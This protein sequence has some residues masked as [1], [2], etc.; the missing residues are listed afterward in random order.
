MK[1]AEISVGRL[2]EADVQFNI[3]LFQRSYVWD[4]SNQW[5]PLWADILQLTSGLHEGMT[6]HFTGVIVIRGEKILP[7]SIP[8]FEIIDGQQRLLTFQLIFCAIRNICASKKYTQLEAD[9]SRYIQNQSQLLQRGEEYKLRPTKRDREVFISLVDKHK[10]ENRGRLYD[11]YQYFYGQIRDYVNGNEEKIKTLFF[12]IRDRFQFIQILIE[13]QDR[14][15]P[16]R[17]FE[18]LNARGKSLLQ[19]DLLRNNLFLRARGNKD[20]LYE[21]YWEHFEDPYWDP[22]TKNGTSCED[23]LQDFL[24]AKLKRAS[25]K[26]EYFVYEREYLKELRDATVEYEFSELKRYSEVYRKMVDCDEGTLLGNRMKFYQTF[27]LT[28]LHPFILFLKCEVNLPDPDLKIVLD[29]LESYTIRRML[30]FGGTR[31]LLRFNLH[32]AEC[33]YRFRDDFSLDNFIKYLSDKD[34]K[35]EKYPADDEIKTAMH[36]HFEQE[37]LHFSDDERIHFP[38]N[39]YVKAALEDLWIN[40]A[41]AIKKKLIR[42][43]LY[44]IELMRRDQNNLTES[45]FFENNLTLEHIMPEAWKGT[46]FLPIGDGVVEYDMEKRRVS[47]GRDL[48]REDKLYADLFP[49]DPSQN[50]ALDTSHRDAHNLAVAR[51]KLLNSIGNLTLITRNLNAKLGNRTFCKKRKVLDKYSDLRLNNEICQSKV[52]DVN[53]IYARADKLI[54]EFCKIWPSLDR[55]KDQ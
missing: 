35:S 39:V 49:N 23:F 18:S 42:Y 14:E 15:K 30:C 8:K 54:A 51:D 12:S 43:I 17:I 47:V 11:A 7:G 44:R 3:P 26:P 19:F 46:W 37:L 4:E 33:I 48:Q 53:E 52:W 27:K 50:D 16:E 24:I 5:A 31:G 21:N 25:V 29:I 6:S 22:E 34:T 32:F 1:P 55:F 13:D 40:T 45:L 9:V 41:G 10:S 2:F 38:N 28:V 36:T 20:D